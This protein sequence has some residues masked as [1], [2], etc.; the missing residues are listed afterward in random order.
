MDNIPQAPR[1]PMNK[2]RKFIKDVYENDMLL[3]EHL[4]LQHQK[5]IIMFNVKKDMLETRIE[6]NK[7]HLSEE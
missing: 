1:K 5:D 7:L 3:L 2:D 4:K 6:M